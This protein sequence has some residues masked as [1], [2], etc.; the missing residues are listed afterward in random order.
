MTLVPDSCKILIHRILVV[1]NKRKS[2]NHLH[3]LAISI[4][5][6][7]N[8]MY[9]WV[10]LMFDRKRYHHND[11]RLIQ[12]AEDFDGCDCLRP[13]CSGCHL[14]CPSCKGTRCGH[15]CRLEHTKSQKYSRRGRSLVFL[16]YVSLII[17]SFQS[18]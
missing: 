4:S 16:N 3:M 13:N 11:G 5:K 1:I 8:C 7:S 9:N 17:F 14:P 2:I 10:S 15:E 6:K 18:E 12:L